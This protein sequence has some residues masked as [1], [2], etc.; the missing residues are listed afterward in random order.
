MNNNRNSFLKEKQKLME[1]LYFLFKFFLLK[2]QMMIKD[3]NDDKIS[4]RR[5]TLFHSLFPVL[6]LDFKGSMTF[7]ITAAL[8]S[9]YTLRLSSL[10]LNI[11]KQFSKIKNRVFCILEISLPLLQ[12]GV[13][14]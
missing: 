6:S 5:H 10:N 12:R 13:I 8:V 11:K 7:E 3:N 2:S 4:F 9:R 14:S 1:T